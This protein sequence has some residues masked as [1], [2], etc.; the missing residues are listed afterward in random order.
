MFSIAV[1]IL[2]GLI[3][4]V[5]NNEVIDQLKTLHIGMKGAQTELLQKALNRTGAALVLDG[6]FGQMT[7]NALVIFQNNH[8]L[9]P[10]GI[11]GPLTW[12]ALEPWLT[13]F[14]IIR[15]KSGDTF[16]R[17][18][19]RYGSQI[20]A[21]EAANPG[22]DFFN[23]QIGQTLI[24]PL[25][26]SVVPGD[27]R[28]TSTVLSYCIAGLKARYPFISS[29]TAGLSVSGKDIPY[30]KMGKGQPEV[31]VNASHHANEWITSPLV[32]KFLENYA[33]AVISGTNI[34]GHSAAELYS[35][36][37][38]LLIPMVNPDGVDLV[39][40][41]TAP[42]E[43]LYKRAAALS[44]NYPLIDFP[45][46]WKANIRGVDLNLQYPAGWDQAREIKFSQ[47]F[48]K[49]GP[50]DYVGSAVLTE[51]ESEALFN[52]TK[53]RNFSI[54]ISYHTQGEV[55]YWKF[56]DFEPENSRKIGEEMARLSGYSLELT[57]YISS[58]AGYKDWFIQDFNKPGYT[59]E[60][61]IG[62][63]PVPISQFDTIYA[64]NEPVMAYVLYVV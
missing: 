10:D 9:K 28:F 17:L 11:A 5:V 42:G 45:A 33:S 15:V 48:T 43:L 46:G 6:I 21:I 18:A 41:E 37:Q 1:V 22:V 31:F 7:Y 50:R 32:M 56:L 64:Q 14:T 29:G 30:L 4:Y 36:S 53:E 58:F 25:S 44:A 38:M 12:G 3:T 20:R 24:I 19:G 62:T 60:A 40:G 39:T 51:P 27:I 63:S 16:Y 57:P 61:G 59:I 2:P 23:L 26:F 13:G 55:I 8:G 47:G 52:F 35:T 34:G 54:T 49:P